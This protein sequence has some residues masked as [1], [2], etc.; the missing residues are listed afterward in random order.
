M[1]GAHRPTVTW[2]RQ[3]APPTR[4]ETPRCPRRRDGAG[5][6]A[7]DAQGVSGGSRLAGRADRS[8]ATRKTRTLRRGSACLLAR[9]R[10]P[11]SAPA[12]PRSRVFEVSLSWRALKLWLALAATAAVVVLALVAAFELHTAWFQSQLLADL[13]RSLT[14]RVEPGPS[15]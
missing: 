14:F 10:A 2:V 5:K 15:A 12:S 3:D 6:H 1:P 4:I 13:G 9:A 7:R 11:S 8:R